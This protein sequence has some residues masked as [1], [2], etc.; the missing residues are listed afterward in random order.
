MIIRKVQG[1]D[2]ME[3]GSYTSREVSWPVED[4]TVDGTL[5]VPGGAGPFPALVFVAGSGPTDRDWNTAL[6]PGTNGSGRLLAEALATTGYATLRYDKRVVGP[7]AQENMPRLAGKISLASHVAELAAAVAWLAGQAEVDRN[8]IGAL[9][10]SEGA[11]HALNYE[12]HA[13]A[14]PLAALVLTAPPGR[15]VGAVA[16]M[17]VA[18]QLSPLPEGARLLQLYDEAIG[19][20]A[21]GN[22]PD[23]DP[24]LPRP[25]QQLLAALATPMNLP[26]ARELWVTDPAAW[27][28]QVTVPVLVLI[29]QKDIQVDWQADGGPLEQAAAG[30][31][32]VTFVYP[33]DANHVLKHEA[34]PRAELNAAD[35]ATY[36]APEALLDPGVLA[37][38]CDW[39]AGHI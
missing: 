26:F 3:P 14:I 30:H 37:A 25:M 15:P 16:H 22:A 5:V 35:A 13:P 38:I 19:R 27:L 36:N 21:A 24:D 12:V 9:T 34:R 20:F 39:L 18:A 11:L 23:P 8:R 2:M 28:A 32:N 29:G 7:H 4:M 10:N 33:P 1:M 6:L 31:T 17:Q